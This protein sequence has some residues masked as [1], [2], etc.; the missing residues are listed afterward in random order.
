MSYFVKYNNI[1][2]PIQIYNR[3]VITEYRNGF[4]KDNLGFKSFSHYLKYCLRY[5]FVDEKVEIIVK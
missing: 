3:Q 5:H 4:K 2:L 1:V